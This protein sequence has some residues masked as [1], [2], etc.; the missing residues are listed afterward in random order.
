MKYSNS[1]SD[2]SESRNE[3]MKF[4]EGRRQFTLLTYFHT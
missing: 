4:N 1:K 3:R 2:T